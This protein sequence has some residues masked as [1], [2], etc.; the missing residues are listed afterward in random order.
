MR[1]GIRVVIL[2]VNCPTL[3]EMRI[4][5]DTKKYVVEQIIRYQNMIDRC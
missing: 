2:S 3:M 5:A 1:F 4:N